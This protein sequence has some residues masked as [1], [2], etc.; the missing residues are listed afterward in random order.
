MSSV[1]IDG[2]AGTTG[3]QIASRLATRDDIEL[4]EIPEAERK[5]A[6]AKKRFFDAADVVIL[7]LPDDAAREAVLLAPEAR[8]LD[9]STAHRTAKDWVYGMPELDPDQRGAIRD[10]KLVS[11]PGC[12]PTG[13][14]LLIR[15]LIDAKILS[16]SVPLRIH[17][18][19]GYSGGGKKLISK[20]Q[21]R[22][23]DAWRTRPYALDL[24]HKHIPEMRHYAGTGPT[25]L[26][27]PMVGHFYK[28]MLVQVPLFFQELDKKVDLR[29]I[30]DIL[31]QRYA[32]EVFVDVL[33]LGAADA[34]DEG[35]ISPTACNDS[36]RIELMVFGN[37]E[38]V[39][40]SA[41]YDNLGKGASGAAVQNLNLMLGLDEC[42]GLHA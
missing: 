19:S 3:L 22:D 7:C 8:V 33:P 42:A 34:L 9:A 6:D 25:P 15:P 24:Q 14:I 41:R 1:F 36:N 38:H 32:S 39:V 31:K 26:F 29:D 18:I 35:F 21:D 10:A 28:G 20:Y 13:F 30:H 37:G 11:N 4:L 27:V 16:P 23:D 2:Q 5:H 17:A 40:L 12:Y